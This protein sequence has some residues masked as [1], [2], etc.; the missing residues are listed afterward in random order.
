MSRVN[1]GKNFLKQPVWKLGVGIPLI[2]LPLVTTLP[3][4][5]VGLILVRAHLRSCLEIPPDGAN[6]VLLRSGSR[7]MTQKTQ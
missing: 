1:I 2:Y 3:F 5:L 4:M 6:V 7:I